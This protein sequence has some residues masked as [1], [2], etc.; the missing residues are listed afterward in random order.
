MDLPC[1]RRVEPV[2][3]SPR[4]KMYGYFTHGTVPPS[5]PC[6]S[7]SLALPDHLRRLPSPTHSGRRWR[8][9]AAFTALTVLF[10]RPTTDRASLAISLVLIGSPTPVPPGDSASPPEVT[11][12]SSLPCRPQTP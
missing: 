6:S 5:R 3:Q 10:S 9:H 7:G 1:T 12:C 2:R 11:H 4:T 8:G